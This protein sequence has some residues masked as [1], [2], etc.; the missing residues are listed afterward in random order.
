MLKKIIQEKFGTVNKFC[1]VL[2]KNKISRQTIYRLLSAKKPNPTIHT[3][4]SLA[5]QLEIDYLILV[6][7]YKEML[8]ESKDET[9]Y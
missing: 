4:I 1:E 3:I 2:D 9:I 7:Y 6:K 5:K 8:E